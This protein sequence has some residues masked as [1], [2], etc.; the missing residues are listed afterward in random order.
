MAKIITD[1]ILEVGASKFVGV[2]TD[3]AS[4]MK[5]AWRKIEADYPHISCYGCA[6]HGL[7]LLLSDLGKLGTASDVLAQSNS[8]VK[9][10]K[11]SQ[12]LLFCRLRLLQSK[13]LQV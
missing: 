6:A 4:N 10:I 12:T 1:V 8:V 2:V 5:A 13:Q 9:E 3:N 7:N 11:R